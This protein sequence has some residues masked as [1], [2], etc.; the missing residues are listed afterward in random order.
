MKLL[1]GKNGLVFGVANHWSIAWA[2]AEAAVEAGARVG[3]NALD[4]KAARKVRPLAAQL[5]APLCQPCNVLD[6]AQLDAFFAAAAGVFDG[7]I[8]FVVH[9]LAFAR[10]ADLSGRFVETSRAGYSQ[11]MEVSAHSLVELTRRALP[12]MTE[13]GSVVTLTYVGAER[14]IPNYNVMGPAKAALEANVRYLANDLGPHGVRVNAISA[15]PIKTVA[16][17]AIPGFRTMLKATAAAAPLRRNVTRAEVANA[18]LF[19]LSDMGAAVTGEVLHVDAG[20]HIL[21]GVA[22]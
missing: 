17:S 3:L 1:E 8:D 11:A 4:E 7:R 15:G 20:A 19:L 14:V 10:R 13:G 2:I 9:S 18:A 12:L 22:H 16:A 21:A 6:D 5:D